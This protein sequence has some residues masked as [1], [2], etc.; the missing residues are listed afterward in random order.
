ML[1]IRPEI[2]TMLPILLVVLQLN[3]FNCSTIFPVIAPFSDL[4]EPTGPYSIA[5]RSA[6]WTDSSRDET[7]TAEM[8]NRKLVVQVWFPVSER[9]DADYLPYIDDP[10][11]RLPAIAKQLRL[12]RS[13]IDHFGEVQTHAFE[14]ADGSDI[15]DA[16][17][18]VIFSHGLSGMRFQ[19]SSIIEELVSHGYVVFAADHSYG[20]NI[21]IFDDGEPAEY[22]AGK[23][24]ALNANF[25][26]TIDL[27][28]IEILANDLSFIINQILEQPA[29]QLLAGI[30]MNPERIGIMGH[31]LGGAAA[32]TTL[33]TD[34]RVDAAMILDGWYAPVPDSIIAS[35][36]TKPLYHL[37]QKEWADK[38]NYERMDEMLMNSSGAVYKMLIPGTLHTDF[39]DM[40]LFTPFSLFIGYTRVQD[41]LWLNQIMRDN[42]RTFFDVYLKDIHPGRLAEII[43]YEEDVTSYLFVPPIP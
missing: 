20:A 21:T 23:R 13:L 17:P 37:G 4:P 40:P 42:T 11:L 19:N 8:D 6:T 22:R 24:R 33:A 35:G 28:Q 39:T 32:L 25:I 36:L 14:T 15:Q 41:P 30:P 10:E 3:L 7:F 27:T 26:N 18:I 31:S 34:P 29:D 43:Q 12:P 9:N 38:G 1:G 16:F 2:R 5:T